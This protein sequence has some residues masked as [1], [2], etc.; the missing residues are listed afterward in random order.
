[1]GNFVRRLGLRTTAVVS[2]VLLIAAIVVV[3]RALTNGSAQDP[4]RFA[5]PGEIVTG[6]PSKSTA[7]DDG[8]VAT[9]PPA[10]LSDEPAIRNRVKAFMMVWLDRH[11][12]PVEWRRQIAE[13]S[14]TNV[15]D[16]LVGVDPLSVPATRITGDITL[17]VL[18]PSFAQAKVPVD[19]GIVTLG[20]TKPGGVWL[21]ASIDFGR[22]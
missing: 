1:M 4:T 13:M 20:L 19:S 12:P 9:P 2:I 14:T 18:S 16:N 10:P 22:G 11:L 17:P 3:G 6:L 7:R 5:D 21:I 8:A 15:S